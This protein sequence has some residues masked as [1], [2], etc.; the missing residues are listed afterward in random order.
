MYFRVIFKTILYIKCPAR[1][2]KYHPFGGMARMQCKTNAN[3][4]FVVHV[5]WKHVNKGI[6]I[7]SINICQSILI[8]LT[9]FTSDYSH[10]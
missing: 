3:V 2:Q 5:C 6:N 1:G 7:Y 4:C 8:T 9:P 10:L